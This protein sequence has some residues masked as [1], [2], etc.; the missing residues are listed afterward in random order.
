MIGF[1]ITMWASATVPWTNTKSLYFGS[2]NSNKHVNFSD[3]AW[4][5]QPGTACTVSFWMNCG[6]NPSYGNILSCIDGTGYVGWQIFYTPTNKLYL[7]Y[8]NTSSH[9]CY[10]GYNTT[11]A[12]GGW[13]HIVMTVGT[14]ATIASSTFYLDG[15]SKTIT[16]GGADNLSGTISYGTFPATA[17]YNGA[18]GNEWYSG[19]LNQVAIWTNHQVSSTDVTTLYNSGTPLQITTQSLA[20]QPTNYYNFSNLDNATTITDHVGSFNGTCTN[21]VSGDFA[22]SVP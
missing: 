13:H 16:S 3:S 7:Y 2:A 11:I 14:A 18:Q 22:S 6:N 4:N 12:Q 1:P 21:I 5:F 17:G 20:A 9:V 10:W 19:Y 8:A 15:S